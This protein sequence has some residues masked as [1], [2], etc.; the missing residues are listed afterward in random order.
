MVS[1]RARGAVVRGGFAVSDGAAPPGARWW[2]RIGAASFGPVP[3]RSVRD[4]IAEGTI[5]HGSLIRAD[6]DRAWVTVRESSFAHLL[7][8]HEV[9]APVPYTGEHGDVLGGEATRSLR[10]LM[11]W[12]RGLTLAAGLLAVTGYGIVIAAPLLFAAFVIGLVLLHRYWAMI[13]DGRAAMSP[14]AAVLPVVVPGLN[15]VWVFVG[16]AGLAREMNSYCVRNGVRF[17]GVCE[18]T[19]FLVAIVSIVCVPL[20]VLGSAAAIVGALSGGS[21]WGG[22]LAV[23]GATALAAPFAGHLS[24]LNDCAVEIAEHH[25][26]AA[27]A[28]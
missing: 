11:R 24:D 3:E 20:A 9:P 12:W 19:G 17:G 1:A 22:A 21:P 15:V 13:Q 6:G 16:V 2:Y 26:G 7:P 4:M 28:S 27:R 23:A 5:R 25:A 14:S 8:P 10:S 18:V